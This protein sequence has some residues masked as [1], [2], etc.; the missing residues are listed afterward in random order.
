[1]I[2][3]FAFLLVAV[4]AN[5]ATNFSLKAAVR[6]LDAG[7]VW[8]VVLGLL[9]SPWTW[10]GGASG[11]LLLASFMTAIRTLPLSVAYPMLTALV[12]VAMAMIEW[13]FQGVS[14]GMWKIVG[15]GMT[16]AGIA[17]VTANV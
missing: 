15:L 6:G 11:A 2:K 16:I 7:S 9:G 17:L 3:S 8:S 14:M 5:L 13:R 1:M 10:I 4:A 12:I